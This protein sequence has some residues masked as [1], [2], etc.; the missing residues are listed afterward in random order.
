MKKFAMFGVFAL[1]L[2]AA[3]SG[4]P[5]EAE[6][7][8]QFVNKT[9]RTVYVAMALY[10]T[11]LHTKG[12]YKIASGESYEYKTTE[13]PAGLL[14]GSV[15]YY[16]YARKEGAKTVYWSGDWIRGKIHP[17]QK[18][19][20]GEYDDEFPEGAVEVGFRTFKQGKRNGDVESTTVT[21]TLN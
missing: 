1:V 6:V 19:D 7:R 2:A 5:A 9:D 3:L 14:N 15:G 10:G 4:S 18:F 12:W 8:V 20:I 11:E 21:F 13:M 16:A 17:T